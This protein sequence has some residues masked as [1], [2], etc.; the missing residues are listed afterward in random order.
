MTNKTR[1]RMPDQTFYRV[2]SIDSNAIDKDTR[3]VPV[4]FSS[5]TPVKRNDWYNGPYNEILGHGEGNVDTKRLS[6]IGVAL[7]NHDPDKVIG[8]V[9]DPQVDTVKKRATA[10]IQFDSDPESDKVYQKVLNNTLKGISVG[11]RVGSWESVDDGETSNDGYKGPA[12]IARKWEPFEVSVVSVPADATVGVGRSMRDDIPGMINEAVHRALHKRGIVPDN[13]S[14]VK[15]PEGTIWA[16]P[17][18]KDFT[19]SAWA[20]VDDDEKERIAGHFAWAKNDPPEKFGDLKLPHHRPADGAVV[21]D[22]VANAAARLDQLDI[23][24]RDMDKVKAHLGAHYEAFGKTAPWD[25]EKE[26]ADRKSVV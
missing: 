18:L 19:K 22:G 8:K 15:A 20:D 21:W 11:Y 13:V 14:T 2:A 3:T 24:D 9:L 16:A 23:P 25:T 4:S 26:G 7:F 12:E 6:D 17:T 1:Q 10:K 5:D